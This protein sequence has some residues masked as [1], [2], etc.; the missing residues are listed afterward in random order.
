MSTDRSIT[1]GRGVISAAWPNSERTEHEL[2]DVLRA[3]HD[4]FLVA[5]VPR[6]HS[7]CLAIAASREPDELLIL[8]SRQEIELIGLADSSCIMHQVSPRK[9]ER[10][11]PFGYKQY[12]H[13]A[14]DFL[15]LASDAASDSRLGRFLVFPALAPLK[16]WRPITSSSWCPI[17]LTLDFGTQLGF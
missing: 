2:T 1:G 15:S 17:K 11:V 6:S 16:V 9:T 3:C 14:V 7:P 8:H 10:P 12:L 4:T 13:L 5:T